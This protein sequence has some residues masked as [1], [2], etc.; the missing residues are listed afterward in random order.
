MTTSSTAV[1]ADDLL[2]NALTYQYNPVAIQRAVLQKLSDSVNGGVNI[3]DPSNPFVFSL[4]SAA[5]LTSAAMMDN[6]ANTRKQYPYSAQTE[7]DLYLH[8]SDMDYVDRFAVPATTQFKLLFPKDETI[9]KMVTDPATGIRKVV[10]PRNTYFTVA[11]TIFSIQ[12]PIEIRQLQHGG[13][14]IVY[15]ATEISPLQALTSNIIDYEIVTNSNGDWI[16]FSFDVQQFDIISQTSTV[17]SA[18]DFSVAINLTDEYYYT[19]VYAEDTNGNWN[20]LYTTHTDQ[21]Y[22]ITKPTAVLKVVDKT[23]TVSIPQI[24]TGT[25]LLS[26]SIRIDVYETKGVLNLILSEYPLEAFVATWQAYDPNDQTVYTAPLATFKTIIPYSDQTVSGGRASLTFDELR[27]RVIQNAIGAPNL[28]ITNAQI[29]T[30]ITNDGYTIVKNID[31]ITNRTFLATKELPPPLQ[32]STSG[33]NNTLVPTT[34]AGVS[35]KTITMSLQ[36]AALINTVIDND[37]SITITPDT[38]YK[39]VNGVISMVSNDEISYLQSLPPDM[40]AIVVTDGGYYYTPFH[41]VL[42]NT[43]SEFACR[44]YYLDDPQIQTKLFVEEN[45]TTLMQVNTKT[46][47]ITKTA[48]GYTVR[49]VTVSGDAYKALQDNQ[50]YVQ[51]AFIPNGEKDLAYLNGI[52]I[53]KTTDNERIFE[54]YINTTFNIDSIDHLILSNFLLY[55]TQSRLTGVNLL[56]DFSIIYSTN[57]AMGTQWKPSSIDSSLGRYL[58][59]GNI[60]GITHEK[61]RV[62][63][64]YSLTTLWARTRSV[65]STI[66]YKTWQVDVPATY[67]ED[68]YQLDANGSAIT[69]DP[70]GNVVITVLR[71][72]GTPILDSN[73]NPVYAH[74]VGDVVLDPSSGDPIPLSSRGIVRQIDLMLIEGVYWF[75][76]DTTT[77]SYRN[78]LTST[79]VSELINDLTNIQKQLLEETRIYYYPKTTLGTIDV[80]VGSGVVQAIKAGQ[81]FSVVL[82]VPGTVYAD[83]DL[84]RKLEATTVQVINNSLQSKVVSLDSVTSDL[85]AQYGEDVISVQLTGLGGSG[86]LQAFTVIDDSARCSIRKRLSVLGDNSLTVEED[87]TVTFVL[88]E[89]NS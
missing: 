84:R 42:D 9:S 26:G 76:N 73:G 70:S 22:D 79:V 31:N 44:P 34:S 35:V 62:L 61:L 13:I 1:A 52:Q 88:H 33:S 17:N 24:Y 59:P 60:V 45:D 85:R 64:G 74:R 10:I 69:F 8:M 27:T 71:A 63:F 21:I 29:Q 40:R 16:T 7:E 80:M 55:T 66:P 37:T 72:K 77:I 2:Q 43:G 51:L 38:I 58:L 86:N 50:V 18:T 47:G 3:V 53:G 20:E 65:I 41:Y 4:E 81:S 23:V 11:D 39:D 89:L 68:V 67:P 30:Y 6:A 12:Y 5:V 19:R 49:V 36:D 57:A 48:N 54:F 87:V 82:Y 56:T 14:Q 46:Y 25:G 83:M 28:P 32:T 78:Y 75:A 15:D